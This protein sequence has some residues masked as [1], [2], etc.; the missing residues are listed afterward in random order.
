M[1]DAISEDG[2]STMAMPVNECRRSTE[3]EKEG[4]VMLLMPMLVST[5]RHQG[6]VQSSTRQSAAAAAAQQLAS[7]STHINTHPLTSTR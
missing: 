4:P 2:G 1:K 7:V 6:V 5:K 3:A